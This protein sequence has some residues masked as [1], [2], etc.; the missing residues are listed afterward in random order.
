MRI[1]TYLISLQIAQKYFVAKKNRIN[2]FHSIF[3]KKIN[4]EQS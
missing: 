1:F 2:L 3:Y 4:Y